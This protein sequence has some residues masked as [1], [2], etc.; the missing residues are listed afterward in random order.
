M[1]E[2]QSQLGQVELDVVFG[3][4]DLFRGDG[5]EEIENKRKGQSETAE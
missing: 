4:H 5:A 3:E 2:R 1:L